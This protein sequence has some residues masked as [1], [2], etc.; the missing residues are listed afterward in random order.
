MTGENH[1]VVAEGTAQLPG[2]GKKC[3]MKESIEPCGSVVQRAI[4][5]TEFGHKFIISQ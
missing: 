4:F 2:V 5:A 1:S 3:S